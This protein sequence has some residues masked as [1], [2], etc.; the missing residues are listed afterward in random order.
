MVDKIGIL[1]ELK[2]IRT[3]IVYDVIERYNLRLRSEGFMDRTIRPVLPSL[4]I[5]VGY[6]CTAKVVGA[7]PPAEDEQTIAS[8][9]VW[10]YVESAP[11]PGVMVVQD[12]DDPPARSCAWGDVATA[13]F[14]RLGCVGAVTNGGVRDLPEVEELGFHL[15]A[16]A[17]VVGHAYIRWIEIDTP[18]KVGSLVVHPGDLLHG[19]EHGVLVIPQEVDLK[20]LVKDI[21]KFLA[22]EA[23]II[24]YT[25]QPDFTVDGL[26][27]RNMEH[28][29][30]MGGHF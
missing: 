27:Q 23:S 4:G 3:P 26:I 12:L 13:I 14:L 29:K 16:P 19:D 20:K 9:D 15:F 28:E 22:S 10:R 18:V 24:D 17:P 30:N 8:G 21:K 11:S 5:M 25:R 2:K 1:E 6:A 7:L